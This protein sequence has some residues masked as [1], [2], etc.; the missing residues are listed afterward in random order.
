MPD[1][2][3]QYIMAVILLDGQL[4]FKAAES[5]ARMSDP[6]VREVQ[7][8][9]NLIG[10]PKFADQERQRPGLVRVHLRDGEAVEEFIP[11]VRGT[12]DNPMTRD[13]VEMKSLD[14]LQDV[15]GVD[16]AKALIQAI[17]ALDR[18]KSVRELRPLLCA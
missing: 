2:N 3:C 14:L 17:W 9:V 15:L 8:R 13:E 6:K 10:D 18:L 7:S 4:T 11:A 12:A 1:I 5:Y 16:W